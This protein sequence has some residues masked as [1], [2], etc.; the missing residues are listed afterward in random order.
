MLSNADANVSSSTITA[1]HHV[2]CA[3][4]MRQAFTIPDQLREKAAE[5]GNFFRKSNSG[6]NSPPPAQMPHAAGKNSPAVRSG[7][8]KTPQRD[9]STAPDFSKI[10]PP[11]D[12]YAIG[13]V[14]QTCPAKNRRAALCCSAERPTRPLRNT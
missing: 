9:H 4:Q 8:Q 7:R 13:E 5:G 12:F 1:C 6:K 11:D 10:R 14:L 3:A 2:G